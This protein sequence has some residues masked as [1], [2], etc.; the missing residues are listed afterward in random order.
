MVSK[1]PDTSK[2]ITLPLILQPKFGSEE[3]DTFAYFHKMKAIATT[4]G[5]INGG[6]LT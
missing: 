4:T 5:I 2:A 6:V 1:I 3:S